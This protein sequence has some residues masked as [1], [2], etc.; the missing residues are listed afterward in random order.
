MHD[1]SFPGNQSAILRRCI[2]F[3]AMRLIQPAFSDNVIIQNS[4]PGSL[5][6]LQAGLQ[7]YGLGQKAMSA[8][9]FSAFN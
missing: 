8:V 1:F 6:L 4:V 3:D 7:V 9:P 2:V 5:E